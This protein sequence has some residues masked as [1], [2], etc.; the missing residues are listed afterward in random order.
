MTA[1]DWFRYRVD[2]FNGAGVRVGVQRFRDRLE[3]LDYG[4]EIAASG[5]LGFEVHDGETRQ[6][7]HYGAGRDG[8][9][10]VAR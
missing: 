6:V 2:L 8:A 10:A 5:R 9:P 1:G 4:D 7:I 3:A